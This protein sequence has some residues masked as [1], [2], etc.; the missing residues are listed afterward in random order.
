MVKDIRKEIKSLEKKKTE[1]DKKINSLSIKLNNESE[2]SEWIGIPGT[3]YEVTKNVLHKGKSYDKIM[4]LKKPEEELLTLKMIGIICENPD[5]LKELKMD[6]SSTNDDFFFKQPF[7]QNK[8]R[9]Y[10]ARFYADSDCAYLYCDRDSSVAYSVLG[11]R[12]VRKKISKE[13]K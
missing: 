2:K 6:S 11:V 7:P 4:Q 3:D 12:F 13:E 1:I 8:E 9:D 10:V 5:L